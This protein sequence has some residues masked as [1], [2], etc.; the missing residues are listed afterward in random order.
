MHPPI[1]DAVN[2]LLQTN[3]LARQIDAA[4]GDRADAF[5]RL[6]LPHLRE[7]PGYRLIELKAALRDLDGRTGKWK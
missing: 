2:A 4:F 6:L 3:A 5:A 1:D 7:L